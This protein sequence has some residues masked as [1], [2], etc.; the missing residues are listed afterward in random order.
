MPV[1]AP[2][3]L[4]PRCLGALN[5]VTETVLTGEEGVGAEPPM[6]VTELG[7]YF[8]QLEIMECLGRGGMGVVYKRGKNR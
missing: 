4:C 1:N 8:P 2:E 7:P 3:G 6:T 5:L